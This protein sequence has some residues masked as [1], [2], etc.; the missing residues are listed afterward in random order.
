[1]QSD[2]SVLVSA[3]KGASL[4]HLDAARTICGRYQDRGLNNLITEQQ[5]D[6]FCIALIQI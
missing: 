5:R 2:R 4:N 1:M 6:S 3:M